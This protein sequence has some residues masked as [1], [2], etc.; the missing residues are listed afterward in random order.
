M[1]DDSAV[2]ATVVLQL[3]GRAAAYP[4]ADLAAAL[5]DIAADRITAA[6]DSL[7]DAGVVQLEAGGVRATEAVRRLDE[8]GLIAI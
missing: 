5:T 3:L 4:R 6:L 8:L 1:T 2:Q 7:A